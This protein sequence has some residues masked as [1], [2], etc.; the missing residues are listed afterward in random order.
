MKSVTI[1]I[2]FCCH[3]LSSFVGIILTIN[4]T[5]IINRIILQKIDEE[6][7]LQGKKHCPILHA[8]TDILP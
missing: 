8:Y 4:T 5:N 2:L 1:Y 6:Y 7:V 3:K